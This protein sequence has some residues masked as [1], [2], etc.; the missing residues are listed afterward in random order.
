MAKLRRLKR[1]LLRQVVEDNIATIDAAA[2][3]R[4]KLPSPWP[5]R[6]RRALLILLPATAVGASSYVLSTAV[7]SPEDRVVITQIFESSP[8]ESGVGDASITGTSAADRFDAMGAGTT[9]EGLPEAAQ[10]P[11]PEP[12]D[13]ALL[14]LG[15]RK[16]ILDPGHGGANTG[17]TTPAGIEEKQLTLDVALRLRRMLVDQ[18]FEVV[19]TRDDDS[20]LELEER[21]RLANQEAGD[22]FV[23]IHV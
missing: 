8:I 11:L 13:P 20:F 2:G 6:L 18:G 5:G 14:D 19:L 7:S 15:V 4:R 16:V 3:R 23:S 12:I 1:R 22:I 17:T 9:A 21:T 10:L